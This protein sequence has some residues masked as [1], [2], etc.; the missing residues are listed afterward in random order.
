MPN[1]YLDYWRTYSPLH[2]EQISTYWIPRQ[3]HVPGE[4]EFVRVRESQE[5]HIVTGNMDGDEFNPT[6]IQATRC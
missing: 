1:S 6:Y 3:F 5:G 4:T 2:C